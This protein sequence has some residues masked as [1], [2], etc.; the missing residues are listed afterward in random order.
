MARAQSQCP[1]R[2][3]KG[4]FGGRPHARTCKALALKASRPD[5]SSRALLIASDWSL[6]WVGDCQRRDTTHPSKL[7]FIGEPFHDVEAEC[8]RVRLFVE[9][10]G[11]PGS[12]DGPRD[13]Q[14]QVRLGYP[15]QGS[16]VAFARY[17]DALFTGPLLRGQYPD[18]RIVQ[19]YPEKGLTARTRHSLWEHPH[20]LLCRRAMA[21]QLGRDRR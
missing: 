8:D 3:R 2:V 9:I 13:G 21:R 12:F 10:V 4:R 18:A 15:T 19:A 16:P 20:A 5:R 14:A 7:G 6:R 17:S 11:H 1:Q